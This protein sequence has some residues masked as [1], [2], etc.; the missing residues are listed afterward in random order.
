MKPLGYKSY[1]SIGHLPGSRMDHVNRTTQPTK[2]AGVDFG[3]HAGHARICTVKTR[4]SHDRVIVQEKMDGS[5]VA[6][7]NVDGSLVAVTRAGRLAKESQYTQ[8]HMF[9]DWV[10]DNLAL[11]E[12]LKPGERLCG[13]WL[14]QAHSTRYSLK[15]EPFVAFDIMREGSKRALFDE[16]RERAKGIVLP[17]L[18]SDGPAIS[19]EAAL[20]RL[21]PDVHGAIDPIE[22]CVW[23]VERHGV[24]DFLAKYVRPDK[25][26]GMYLPEI[27]GKEIV[28]NWQPKSTTGSVT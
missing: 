3:V 12:F 9:A 17:D 1:G 8:H 20:A 5:N 26:A 2:V 19:V 7:A 4:D 27:S 6:V 11:F 16:L 21:N 13:E 23:R 28:W 10:N 22:G 25:V 24:V 18:I 15:H 14:A